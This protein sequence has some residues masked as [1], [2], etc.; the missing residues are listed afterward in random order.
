MLHGQHFAGDGD[1]RAWCLTGSG[2]L[3]GLLVAGDER[4]GIGLM[5]PIE[6]EI[7]RGC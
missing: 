3:V 4:D 2:E 5:I 6:I 7:L 1:A